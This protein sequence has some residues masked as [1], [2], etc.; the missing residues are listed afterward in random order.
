[1]T[2]SGYTIHSTRDRK[3]KRVELGFLLNGTN[4]IV[5]SGAFIE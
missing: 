5:K 3:D 2:E 1:M 4:R